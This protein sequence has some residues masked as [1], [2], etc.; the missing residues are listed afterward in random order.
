MFILILF[1]NINFHYF[2]SDRIVYYGERHMAMDSNK[3][4]V[5]QEFNNQ[6]T[7]EEALKE[8]FE[9]TKLKGVCLPK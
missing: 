5:M 6:A 2:D 1:V 8:I 9:S 4:V 3:T 7:C